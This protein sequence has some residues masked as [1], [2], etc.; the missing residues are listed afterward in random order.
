MPVFVLAIFRAIGQKLENVVKNK[1][2]ILLAE[3]DT[4]LAMLIVSLLT[5]AGCDVVVAPNSQK[6]IELAK[7]ARFDL[8]ALDV[9]LPDMNGFAVCDELKQRH[10]SR[11]TPIIFIAGSLCE[12]DLRR[13]LELGASDFITKPFDGEEFVQCLLSHVKQAGVPV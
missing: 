6:G 13:G 7:E 8:F 9:D 12:N 11:N 3:S 10:I 2:K 1:S 4:P 5:G